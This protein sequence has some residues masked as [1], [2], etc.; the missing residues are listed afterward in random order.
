MLLTPDYE[1]PSNPFGFGVAQQQQQQQQIAASETWYIPNENTATTKTL[2]AKPDI[3][4]TS[5]K[6]VVVDNMS[7]G[8]NGNIN[9]NDEN[10]IG[11]GEKNK[12]GKILYIL[13]F[14]K[15]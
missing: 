10:F 6:V 9:E 7:K 12:K 15:R 1:V 2:S 11:D 14:D 3:A 13:T 4:E 8:E 5:Q